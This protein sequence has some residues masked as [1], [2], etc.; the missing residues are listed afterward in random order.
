[1]RPRS[2]TSGR[3]SGVQA[4]SP[5]PGAVGARLGRDHAGARHLDVAPDLAELLLH[6]VEAVHAGDLGD[7]VREAERE[8]ELRPGAHH[9]LVDD[10]RP[11][12]RVRDDLV[13]ADR[14]AVHEDAVP[15]HDD[16]VEDD[17]PVLLVEARR[18]RV[19]ERRPRLGERVA[20]DDLEARRVH[21]QREAERVGGVLGP[22]RAARVDRDLV[23]VGR[24]RREHARA[25]HDDPLGRLADL[26]QRD[27][28]GAG[29]RVGPRAVDLRVHDRVRRREVVLAH[30]LVVADEILGPALVAAA[31]P[32]VG[33][34]GEQRERHVEVVGRAAHDAAVV[35]RHVRAC[36]CGG[37]RD[38]RA[39]AA[40]G[41]RR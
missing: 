36:R 34:R 38:P 28:A 12:V 25:A 21:R 22:Q 24:E 10:L 32:D 40:A 9:R 23:G 37:A 1:M 39:S 30:Q 41:T 15:G 16:V 29:R 3:S 14:V 5:G 13:V 31:R 18:E 20:Q 8:L 19:V 2:A 7:R 6:V 11:P 17:H 33:A 27:L 26:V 35:L 4:S